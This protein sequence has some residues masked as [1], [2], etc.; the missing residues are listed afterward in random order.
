VGAPDGAICPVPR[1]PHLARLGVPVVAYDVNEYAGPVPAVLSED[2]EA[3]RL[4]AEHLLE[5]GHRHFAFCAYQRMGWSR[6]R[7]QA[8]CRAIEQAGYA[9]D[10]YGQPRRGLTTWAKEEPRVRRWIEALP[11]PVGL[12]CAN[13]DGAASVLEVCRA[14]GCGVPEDVSII[15][16]DDDEYVCDLLNPPLSSVKMASDRAGYE[17][18]ALLDRMIRRKH[19]PP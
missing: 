12:L 10:V 3:G 8:F 11:K 2:A 1:L 16:V 7:C 14:L 4:A 6:L 18:A 9:V 19:A 5:L 15:G 13:D 17:A